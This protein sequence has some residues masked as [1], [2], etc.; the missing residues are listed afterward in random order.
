MT[1]YSLAVDIGGTF[2][3]A[4]LL[5]DDGRNFVDKTL[6]THGNLLEGFFRGVELVMNR[7]GVEPGDVNDMVVHA[8]TVVTNALIERKGPPVGLILTR[9]FADI[10][11]IRD[12][13][14]YD[15]YDPQIE[16]AEPLIPRERTWVLSERILADGSV[17]LAPQESEIVAIARGCKAQ[18]IESVAVSLM[19]AYRNGANEKLVAEIFAREAPEIFVSLSSEIAPQMREYL[20][21]STTAINAYTVP[22]TR[23]YLDAL[24]AELDRRGFAQQPLIMLSNGGVIGAG[25][26]GDLP[27]RMIESG[28]AAG[29]L[30]ACYFSRMFGI[31]DLISFDMGGTTAKACMIQGHEPLVTGT[32]E[33]DRRYRF[34]P[35]S[36]MPI[37]VPSIDMIEIG[38]GGGS[39]AWVDELGLL[40]TGPESAGS[41]PG[42]VC[43]GRGGKEPCITDADV[44]LGILDPDRFLGGDMTLDAQAAREA[45][46]R[47]GEKIGLTVEQT[48]WG[49]YEVVCEQMAAAARTHATDRGVDYRGLPM[50]AFGGA[51]PVHAC[52]V[53]DLIES[54]QVI[55]PPLASVLSAFGTLVTPAQIDLVRSQLTAVDSLDGAAAQRLVTQMT[56]EGTAAL[57]EAGL[58]PSDI[59]FVFGA[60][61]RYLGQQSELRVD[62]PF[63]PREE[64][65]TQVMREIFEREYVV[66]YGLKLDDIPIEI[67]NWHVTARGKLPERAT[68]HVSK[69]DARPEARKRIVHLRGQPVETAVYAR[70][71]MV[72]GDVISGPVIVEERETTIFVLPGWTIRLHPN[73]SLVADKVMEH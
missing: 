4:V 43:Y 31:R 53:A 58:A 65:D 51:G 55:Y 29:A 36:G 14:R 37:T 49:I 24:I 2:T 6:T 68:A 10:L 54:K 34:K 5:A 60:E 45:I 41:I 7:A 25:R 38:A 15:M 1:R 61:L 63:D 42:P 70:S 73:G 12:E 9:G 16:F 50:L 32:F 19:N 11:Y 39:I 40:R 27:V 57:T 56:E 20:R 21:T 47:L 48:A 52:L 17:E 69:G 72:E 35:G 18:G 46:K 28:P 67:V 44:V 3:D 22:I 33:V 64:L 23:P 62:L 71:A 26:A 66:Q 13:H 30:V 8:T 59:D